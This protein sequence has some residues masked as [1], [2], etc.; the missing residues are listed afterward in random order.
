MIYRSTEDLFFSEYKRYL[1]L[2]YGHLSKSTINTYYSDS[3]GLVSLDRGYD[4]WEMILDEDK[5][6][7][8]KNI[9]K[10]MWQMW[11][12]IYSESS[13]ATNGINAIL[14]LDKMYNFLNEDV[15]LNSRIK[16][17][18]KELTEIIINHLRANND[19]NSSVFKSKMSEMTGQEE[20]FFNIYLET[21]DFLMGNIEM[22][23][24][25]SLD[26]LYPF[27]DTLESQ[28]LDRA[29]NNI[30]DYL[31]H[32]Y[33]SSL[34]SYPRRYGELNDYAKK[35]N[36]S[37][38]F[39]EEDMRTYY[40]NPKY[41]LEH[42]YW[43]IY[44][45]EDNKEVYPKV[46]KSDESFLAGRI[47][48]V[49]VDGNIIMVREIII[50]DSY[51]KFFDK[52]LL[53]MG[54]GKVIKN[55][56]DGKS[57][58]I[59]WNEVDIDKVWYHDSFTADLAM[60]TLNKSWK[61]RNLINFIEGKEEQDID[62]YI[63]TN[64][65]K[66]SKSEIIEEQVTKDNITKESEFNNTYTKTD[67]LEEVFI[68]E[69]EYERINILLNNKQNIIIQGAPG[70]G[71][72]FMAKRLAYSRIGNIQKENVQQIQFHQS[73]GYE[74]LM[75][76]Y[77]PTQE[78]FELKCGPFY[79]FCK[80]ASDNPD[81]EYY[82]IIDE[83]NR[84]N[85]SKIFGELLMLIETDKRG[86]ENSINLMY[87]GEEFYV[88]QNIYIIGLMNTADRS[89][90]VLD[91]ALRRRFSFYTLNPAFE[92]KT[93]QKMI[94]ETHNEKLFHLVKQVQEINKEILKDESLG[95]GFEIGHSYFTFNKVV[96]DAHVRNI[97]DY[98]INPLLEEY[99]YDDESKT[100]ECTEN[101]K[102]LF[103]E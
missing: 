19:L 72:T 102:A 79:E 87:T 13:T 32:R 30:N 66:T 94:N 69:K 62:R 9:I 75:M 1:E 8:S 2:E 90:A 80:R 26:I 78:G 98:D 15:E 100:I 7:E 64:G 63:Q 60:L 73:Y 57:L 76:G 67:F 71:K 14:G 44:S 45:D 28:E 51:S 21:Y 10:N 53:I 59:Q 5:M 52:G 11:T 103:N 16:K 31:K 86:E 6:A 93:F 84:G 38:R 74:D 55:D 18:T 61:R 3:K 20:D 41:D 24:S 99:W 83:I 50:E 49:P 29:L 33:E 23:D 22:I 17:E 81:Q 97:I 39:H 46:W 40:H 54:K 34:Y 37:V 96:D 65:K 47:N 27:L 88:P 101:L 42:T 82:F 89:L 92:N 58:E 12:E 43:I 36:S 95:R 85:I 77:R 91:Y 48:R 35:R 68:D 70:V 4:F 56:R 25:L